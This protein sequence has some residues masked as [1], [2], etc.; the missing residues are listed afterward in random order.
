M[1]QT[2]SVSAINHGTVIDHI[3][4]GQALRIMRLLKMA[5]S[6]N[7]VTLGLNLSSKS[8]GTK[9]LIKIENKIL[10]DVEANEIAVFAPQVTINIIEDF[11]VSKKIDI[12]MPET[13]CG[14]LICPNSRC[15][16]QTEPVESFFYVEEIGKQVKLHCKYC[17]KRF[18]RDQLKERAA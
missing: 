18:D 17:E 4:A 14:I 3:P 16:T 15:V 2:L 11:K 9:D 10:S 12:K 13:I 6:K 1:T 7:C 5:A 8:M